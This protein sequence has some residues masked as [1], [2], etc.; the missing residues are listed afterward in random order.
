[1]LREKLSNRQIQ[2]ILKAYLR[3]KFTIENIAYCRGGLFN[4]TVRIKL[5]GHP[6]FILQSS[7]SKEQHFFW[8]EQSFL[9]RQVHFLEFL[10]RSSFP[11]AKAL[12]KDFSGRIINRDYVIFEELKGH[13]WHYFTKKL[14][15]SQNSFIYRQLGAYARKIHDIRSNDKDGFGFP[16]PYKKFK[17]WSDFILKY[18]ES[19]NQHNEKHHLV[20]TDN[21]KTPFT[22]AKKMR[23]IF[24]Q[25]KTPRLVHGDLWPRNILISKEEN[26]YRIS[27]ILDWERA[28]WGDVR[29]EWVLHGMN[30]DKAFWEAYGVDVNPSEEFINRDKL[31]KAGFLYQAAL[32]EAYYFGNRK[33]AVDLTK[34]M[35]EVVKSIQI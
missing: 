24:D 34:Q 21:G 14:T 25:I 6:R 8:H 18:Y 31:Y 12:Y 11:V 4:T 5:K 9:R 30:Y 27:G 32:E 35:Q 7:S 17:R 33:K 28:C 19:L 16:S 29:F 15:V 3:E 13:N 26:N 23:D 1:M 22:V 2:D 20:A 10:K